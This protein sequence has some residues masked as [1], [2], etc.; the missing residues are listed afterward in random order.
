MKLLVGTDLSVTEIS[1]RCG[2][3]SSCYMARVFKSRLHL[4]PLQY[5]RKR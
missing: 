5:R 1:S 2:F 4:T 3:V